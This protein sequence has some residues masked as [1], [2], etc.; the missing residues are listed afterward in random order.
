METRDFLIEVFR[1]D[2]HLLLVLARVREHLDLRHHLVCEARRHHKARMSRRATEI[3][4]ASL[5]EDHHAVAVREGVL[6]V[7]GLDVDALDALDLLQAGHVDLVVKVADVADNR[8]VLHP[9][10]VASSDDVLIAG[11]RNE[12]VGGGDD[13]IERHDLITGH[14]RL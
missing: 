11:G 13:V 3:H 2:V 7:L 6:V 9:R 12:D 1:Q 5:G 14:A 4:Q 10:H 8:F